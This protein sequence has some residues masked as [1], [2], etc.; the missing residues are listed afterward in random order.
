[1]MVGTVH[2]M[3]PE[4]VRG[5]KLDGRSDVFS[6]G[7]IL[8]ELL[9]GRRPFKGEGATDVLYKI[10][11]EAPAPLDLAS[12]GALSPRLQ[13]IVTRA[14]AKE[15]QERYPTATQLADDL[16]SVLEMQRRAEGVAGT[17]ASLQEALAM[18]RRQVKE[19]RMEEVV[20]R[21]R[22]LQQAHPQ[23]LE[24]RRALRSALREK[25]RREKPPEP[26]AAAFPELEAT[27]QNPPTSREP[28][29]RMQPTVVLP[30]PRG[31]RRPD[32]RRRLS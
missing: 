1:M 21:L 24:T 16:A 27:F 3:S 11:H 26:E 14:L 7:V 20:R 6:L 17:P 9:A 22:E 32:A 10:V 13:E 28:E 4:Q 8:Y 25:T 31:R 30:E 18:A 2:Y 12:L 29:T 5:Q 23:S 15:V 19:G